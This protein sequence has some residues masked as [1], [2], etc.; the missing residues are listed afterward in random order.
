M[1]T[2]TP[3]FMEDFS[4]VSRELREFV[5]AVV[6]RGGEFNANFIE[7]FLE[8]R[9]VGR[10]GM[11]APPRILRNSGTWSRPRS[12]KTGP[13]IAAYRPSKL[14]LATAAGN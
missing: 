13:N 3:R 4:W 9:R 8:V 6:A 1:L 10:S 11:S 2:R 12:P 7:T 5:D 14:C